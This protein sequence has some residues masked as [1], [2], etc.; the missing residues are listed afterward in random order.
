MA[1][2]DMGGPPPAAPSPRQ[3]SALWNGAMALHTRERHGDAAELGQGRLS[4]VQEGRGSNGIRKGDAL[5]L[6]IRID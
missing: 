1:S 4:R 2:R 3:M 5:A 6:G